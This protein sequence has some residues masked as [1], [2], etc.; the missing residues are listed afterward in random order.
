MACS[1]GIDVGK[2][3][4]VV[5][6]RPVGATFEV[7]NDAAGHRTLVQ[8]LAALDGLH[9]VV[10]EA[11]GGYEATALRALLSAG[12][13]AVRVPPNRIRAFARAMGRLAKTDAVDAAVLA[14]Y[15]EVA[16]LVVQ[17][18]PSEAEVALREVVQRRE[19][20]VAQRDD[21][22]RRLH[23][24]NHGSVRDSL[25]R[26]IAALEREIARFDRLLQT[27]AQSLPGYA[28]LQGIKGLGL[29]TVA[30]LLAQLPE[31]G[32]LNRREVAALA[33]LAPWNRDSGQQHGKR[34]IHGGRAA[35]RRVLYM[36][37]WSVIRMQARF[38][39]KYAAL[40]AS[41]K[42]AKVA[43]VACMRSLLVSLNAM[44]RDGTPWRQEPHSS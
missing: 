2:A 37:T 16:D 6:V 20:L 34:S 41:G 24:A 18:G 36:A 33:G 27:H 35:I 30:T 3:A 31:L 11:T 43:I 17:P 9:R 32:G 40:R 23:R 8:R 1:V 15:A 28:R 21:E 10:L 7:T 14:H 42:V 12:L 38:R 25:V 4:L 29:I 44:V 39:S 5:H 22:R 13:P 19:Q 26:Q